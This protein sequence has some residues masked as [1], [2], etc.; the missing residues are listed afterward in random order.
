[1]YELIRRFIDIVF[2]GTAILVL[3][4]L[5]IP[6]L[7]ALRLTGEGHVFYR[8]KRVGYRNKEFDILKLA[9]MLKDSPNMAGGSITMRN[10]PRITPL[11]GFLRRSKL[12]EV[13]Q[14]WNML[15]GEMSLVG[16]RP[17]MP[18]SFEM[19]KP[20]VQA[21]VYRTRPGLTG[22]ASLIFRDEEAYVSATDMDPVVFYKNVI[23]AYKGELE[24][25]YYRNRSMITDL[26]ILLLTGW[27]V[28]VPKSTAAFDWFS[29]LPLPPPE[30]PMGQPGESVGFSDTIS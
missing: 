19:Y 9:T 7:I 30:L 16:P 8:Q 4:P 29:D 1:M 26:R 25:W 6:L 24:L 18:V 20:E 23:C 12:N 2:A 15:V 13:P 22:I 11:G 28:L 14:L 27:S 10:D 3:L 5:G 17:L 21:V